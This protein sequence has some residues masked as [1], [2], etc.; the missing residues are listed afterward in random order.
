VKGL[1]IS[2]ELWRFVG[3]FSKVAKT[4]H[5]V[6]AP[7]LTTSSAIKFDNAVRLGA[8]INAGKRRRADQF[9]ASA[10]TDDARHDS[11]GAQTAPRLPPLG[12][13]FDL[14]PVRTAAGK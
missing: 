8:Q 13:G 12:H 3:N 5:R 7:I 6:E 1:T 11:H 2:A 4:A 9:A 14:P 10:R